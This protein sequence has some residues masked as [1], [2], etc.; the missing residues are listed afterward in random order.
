MYIRQILVAGLIAFS[1]NSQPARAELTVED[2]WNDLSFYAAI[3]G[4]ELSGDVSKSVAGLTVSNIR[5]GFQVNE[6]NAAV[7]ELGNLQIIGLDDGRV[8]LIYPEDQ[9]VIVQDVGAETSASSSIRIICR[10]HHVIATGRP[11]NVTYETKAEELGFE[12]QGDP[13]Q[14]EEGNTVETGLKFLSQGFVG[15]T[16]VNM[17][18]GVELRHSASHDALS[19]YVSSQ[20]ES[21]ADISLLIAAKDATSSYT[22]SNPKESIEWSDFVSAFKEGL[23]LQFGF[24]FGPSTTEVTFEEPETEEIRF[25]MESRSGQVKYSMAKNGWGYSVSS[26]GITFSVPDVEDTVIPVAGTIEHLELDTLV[27]MFSSDSLQ[28]LVLK[29]N[30]TNLTLADD[31]WDEF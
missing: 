7:L 8:Q 20:Q 29:G 25:N 11:G 12:L 21:D 2:V 19:Y 31:F 22:L 17:Q 1:I 4:G 14:D 13:R 27:P 28:G 10:D 30:V 3:F 24:G 9:V 5:V 6:S 23:S 16:Q 18:N 15:T 26:Q